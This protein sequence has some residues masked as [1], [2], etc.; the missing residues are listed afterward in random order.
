MTN[1]EA[2]LSFLNLIIE[3]KIREAYDKYVSPNFRHHNPYFNGDRE[4]LL[5]AMEESHQQFPYKDYK[6]QRALEDGDL[7]AVHSRVQLKPDMQPIAV[8]HILRFENGLI[9]E[10]W[11]AGQEAPKDMPNEY[12]MF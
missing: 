5:V 10:E 4:S 12:G 7:V 2:A 8:V 9:V 6:I 3:G 1:K 11:E